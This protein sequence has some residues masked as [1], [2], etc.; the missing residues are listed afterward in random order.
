MLYLSSD[1]RLQIVDVIVDIDL[2]LDPVRHLRRQ[3]LAAHVSLERCAH[4]EDVEV[5]RAGRDRLL[6]SRVVVGLGKIDP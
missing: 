3:S 1:R 5:D 4:F 6:Q 2:L